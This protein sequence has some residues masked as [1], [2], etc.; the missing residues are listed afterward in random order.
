MEQCLLWKGP[1]AGAEDKSEEG[2]AAEAMCDELTATPIYLFLC[3][4]QGE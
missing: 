2:E 4:G 1:H 3:T